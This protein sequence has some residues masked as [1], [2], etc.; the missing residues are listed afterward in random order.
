MKSLLRF[1]S[2][3]SL[4]TLAFAAGCVS[5]TPLEKDTAA[6]QGSW[7]LVKL[8]SSGDR[9]PSKTEMDGV[10]LTFKGNQMVF[11]FEV[12]VYYGTYTID[13]EKTPKRLNLIGKDFGTMTIYRLEGDTLTICGGRGGNRPTEFKMTKEGRVDLVVFERVKE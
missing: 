3:L 12:K 7:K 6:L 1:L 11:S 8:E 4:F 9:N 5:Q 10:R 13:P 2:S